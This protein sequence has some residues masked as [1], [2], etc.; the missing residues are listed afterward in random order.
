MFGIP[1]DTALAWANVIS[2]SGLVIAAAG[3]FVAY[4][5][6]ARMNA[7]HSL[8]LQQVQS[9]ARTQIEIVAAQ[10]N[11][12]TAGLVKANEELQLELQ[13]ER[14]AR[15]AMSAQT[16][17]ITNEQMAKF[18]DTVKGKVRQINLFTAPDREASIF[19]I[20]ILDALQKADVSV[21]WHRMQSLPTFGRGIADN[22]V[23][24]Y[25]YPAEEK[26]ESVGRTLAKA[27]TALDVQP[28]L[29][30]PTQPLW[31]LPSP[32]LI[33][34]PTPPEFLRAPNGPIPSATKSAVLSDLL[35]HAE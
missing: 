34:A 29:L 28:N 31:D 26:D 27:F 3:A 7:G 23:T 6:A 13:S 4:Q 17:D 2:L 20:T 11:T 33:I 35:S 15:K 18:V 5:L 16:R 25:E 12:R 10:A 1:A 32:S 30:I 14:K 9:E 21:T 24:I 8:E 22:G 19:G